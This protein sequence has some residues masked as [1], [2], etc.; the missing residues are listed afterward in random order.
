M[1]LNSLEGHA[2]KLSISQY[3]RE[4][5][6]I[7]HSAPGNQPLLNQVKLLGPGETDVVARYLISTIHYTFFVSSNRY[8]NSGKRDGG[9]DKPDFQ[10]LQ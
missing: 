4:R 9:G 8:K 2:H 6:L 5:F 1:L 3:L 10:L 7:H